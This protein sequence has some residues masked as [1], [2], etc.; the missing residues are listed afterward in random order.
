MVSVRKRN[1]L[2]GEKNYNEKRKRRSEQKDFFPVWTFE[3]VF[4]NQLTGFLHTHW[5]RSLQRDNIVGHFKVNLRKMDK[6]H[7]DAFETPYLEREFGLAECVDR[8]RADVR[9]SEFGIERGML[10]WSQSH[11]NL[12]NGAENTQKQKK[13]VN[14]LK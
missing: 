5:R 2:K 14:K 11:R 12:N 3:L 10:F 6:R 4:I 9:L 7:W 13:M 1:N 8:N